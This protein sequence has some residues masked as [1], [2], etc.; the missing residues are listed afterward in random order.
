M[1]LL[2][3]MHLG[4]IHLLLE[5]WADTLL[6]AGE[7]EQVRWQLRGKNLSPRLQ[8]LLAVACI[9][10]EQFQEAQVALLGGDLDLVELWSSH[11][12]LSSLDH[13]VEGA[14]GLYQLGQVAEGLR[15]RE[16]AY[17]CYAKCLKL[18]P[19]MWCAFERLSWLSLC[20]RNKAPSQNPREFA[21]GVFEH[22]RLMKNDILFPQ[23]EVC[24]AVT[25]S[26]KCGFRTP[27]KRR[28]SGSLHSMPSA[29]SAKSLSPFGPR[30]SPR[31]PLLDKNPVT[32]IRTW[33]P[34][35]VRGVFSP[36][37]LASPKSPK[38]CHRYTP[39][40]PGEVPTEE[41]NQTHIVHPI[42][43]IDSIMHRMRKTVCNVCNTVRSDTGCSGCSGC[44]GCRGRGKGGDE[45]GDSLRSFSTLLQGLGEALHSLH[46]FRCQEA[47]DA[48]KTLHLNEQ[49]SAFCEDLVARCH[50]EMQNYEETVRSY[51]RCCVQHRFFRSFGFEY[52]STALWQ[53]GD[54]L[55]LGN[56]S[57]QVLE[58][59]RSRPRAWCVLG[60]CFSLNNEAEEAIKFF[61]RAIQLDPN[62]V[63]AYSLIGHELV[64]MEKYEKAIEMFQAAIDLDPRQ[65]NAWWGLGDVFQRQED[66][67][68]A[69]YNFLRA[70]DINPSN[71]VLKISLG[72]VLQE[73]GQANEALQLLSSA[74]GAV[75]SSRALAFL[76]KG[77]LLCLEARHSEAV[78]ELRGACYLAP[79]EPGIHFHLGC[80]CRS[81]GDSVTA[82]KHFTF[83]LD[84]A[85]DRHLT[86]A[87]RKE[88]RELRG[89]SA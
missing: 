80:A 72:A 28:R 36:Q 77:R 11:G 51:G 13:V 33:S 19:F 20:L 50:F 37:S 87:T 47:I 31:L 34:S 64:S 49:R 1:L 88:L 82:L 40:L 30:F 9:K 6:R 21:A 14:A 73:M 26:E 15:K 32:P 8:Y 56:L 53:L 70:L 75:S 41:P 57:R 44:S 17:E 43:S 38:K 81:L 62:L 55:E 4:Q 85:N 60:N 78:E 63:Y 68:Q 59:G 22:D 35:K 79:K 74:G 24:K 66:F 3:L 89:Q 48:V 65:Y 29:Q 7:Y 25:P 67:A 86:D 16:Q 61:K 12:H 71:Q 23:S 5:L 54:R 69:K 52:F 58:W 27:R 42:D 46:R 84:L 76:Q 39:G 45:N 18:C 2:L 83:A 10:L